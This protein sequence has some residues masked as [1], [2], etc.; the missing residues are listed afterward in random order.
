MF[1]K[2]LFGDLFDFNGDGKLDAFEQAADFGMFC[3]MM[4]SSK[5]ESCGDSDDE[6]EADA[7]LIETLNLDPYDIALMDEDE[8]IEAVEDA[9]LDPDDYDLF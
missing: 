8:L 3:Q 4:E 1:E 6:P 7:D 2:G 5:K 9:G